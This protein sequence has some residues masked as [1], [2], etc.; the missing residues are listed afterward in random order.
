MNTSC[1]ECSEELDHCH[2]ALVVHLDEAVECTEPDCDDLHVVRHA[3][4]V[5]RCEDVDKA[6]SCV[7]TVRELLIAS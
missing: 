3:L 2:G 7:I 6:C 1:P 5:V 4:A